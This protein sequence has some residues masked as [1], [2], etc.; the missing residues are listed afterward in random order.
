MV[1]VACGCNRGHIPSSGRES[2]PNHPS[3]LSHTK[4]GASSGVHEQTGFGEDD[5]GPILN[6]DGKSHL[7]IEIARHWNQR[8]AQIPS[9][10]SEW[11]GPLTFAAGSQTIYDRD[12]NSIFFPPENV[13]GTA[14]CKLTIAG[15][16]Q[17]RYERVGPELIDQILSFGTRRYLS[18]T[19]GFDIFEF[20]FSIENTVI[21][22]RECVILERRTAF[23]RQLLCVDIERD[24]TPLRF[25]E[26]NSDPTIDDNWSLGNRLKHVVIPRQQQEAAFVRPRWRM[27]TAARV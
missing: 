22:G 24:Y 4:P 19:N 18:V 15:T 3:G 7:T 2:N 23:S 13:K 20:C 26:Y 14:Q 8:E 21:D 5:R 27:V 17:M 12:D 25:T 1:V 11:S 9:L 16:D 10:H 6:A